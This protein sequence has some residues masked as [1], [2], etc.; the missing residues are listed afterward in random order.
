KPT[1]IWTN[2]GEW[3]VWRQAPMS[4]QTVFGYAV[5]AAKKMARTSAQIPMAVIEEEMRKRF[6]GRWQGEFKLDALGVRFWDSTADNPTGCQVK[7]DGMLCFTGMVGF[8][9][10]AAIF[11]AKW[12][13]AQSALN[14][15]QIAGDTYF[16]GRSFFQIRFGKYQSLP[17]DT[18]LRTLKA[19]GID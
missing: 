18:I 6:P 12:V 13:D 19:Q 11:G 17:I 5:E 3:H 14:L 8:M 2:G 9:S 10:W 7:P 1:Q 16:D 4:W 15:G